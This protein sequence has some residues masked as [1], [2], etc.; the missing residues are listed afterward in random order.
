[1]AD[2]GHSLTA[3]A[4]QLRDRNKAFQYRMT[5]AANR[6]Q[7][8]PEGALRALQACESEATT[9]EQDEQNLLRQLSAPDAQRAQATQ[10]WNT[11]RLQIL[12]G[13]ANACLLLGQFVE[14][15][16][17]VAKARPLAAADPSTPGMAML[18]NLEAQISMAEN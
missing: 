11:Q 3:M 17:V 7:S 16:N 1:M 12:I 15:R 14:A 8:D 9:L 6:I 5:E 18:A 2:M 4:E 13:Q 10:A